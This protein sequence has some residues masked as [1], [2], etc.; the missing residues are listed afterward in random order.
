MSPQ[1]RREYLATIRPRYLQA[2]RF[3]KARLLDEVCAATGYHRKYA[4]QLLR[5]LPAP[6]GVDRHA[7]RGARSRSLAPSG[8]LPAIPGPFGSTRSCH[9]GSP[10][11]SAA[12]ASPHRW[13]ARR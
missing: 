8:K 10:G 4:I 13:L 3:T 11:P 7:T 1:A 6:D 12:S 5:H 2:V 9:C